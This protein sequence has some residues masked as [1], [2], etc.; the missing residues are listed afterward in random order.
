M[1]L[2][3]MFL[4]DSAL[5]QRAWHQAHV[6]SLQSADLC[7]ATGNISVL[8]YPL[9]RLGHLALK[10]HDA[11]RAAALYAESMAVNS[12][13]GDRQGVAASL[14]GLAAVA[15]ALGQ[16]EQAALLLGAAEAL[17]VSIETKLLPFDAE[18]GGRITALVRSQLD[19]GTFAAAWAKGRAMVLDQAIA[20]A[21]ETINVHA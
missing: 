7:R 13:V 21:W 17:V 12:E 3:L 19:A 14:V 6:V 5:G 2:A 4:G 11:N 18:E 16:R 1:C 15:M 20:A 8:P 10:E 9:R